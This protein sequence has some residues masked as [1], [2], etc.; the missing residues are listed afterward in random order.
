MSEVTYKWTLSQLSEVEKNGLK[1]FSTFS[2][3]GGSSLGYK[4]A[5]FDV[6]GNCEIDPQMMKL[7]KRNIKPKYTFNMDIREFNKLKDL[8]EE[9]FHLDVLDGSPPC[10]VFSMSGDREEAWNKEKAFK[11]GQAVQRL[12]DLF[13]HFLE[14]VEKLRPKVFVA[15]NVR[16]LI[17]GNAK[18]YVRE[19]IE[20]AQEKG[21]EVQLFLLNAATM[22]VPQRR[23]RVFFVGRRK[24]LS[25]DPLKL[26]FNEKPITYG[27]IRSGRG[28]KLNERSL[29][30]KR[31]VKR[32][33]DDRNMANISKRLTGKESNF[34]TVLMKNH[35]VAPT[36]AAN[37][38]FI[39]FD[40]PYYISKKDTILI[41]T[42]PMDYDFMDAPVQ[43]VCGMS[44]P[45]LMMRGIAKNIARQW[46]K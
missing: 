15:E 13:F 20:S 40:E 38:C 36:L 1:V 5:G 7:Y 37:S 43:Y 25:F 19:I 35:L 17:Q 30:Y 2:C 4:L 29:A 8:P 41:Q 32:K 10:S 34:N 27:E 46:F 31:W 44:V 14:T 12:D 23:E 45:P 21:Y 6:L 28:R 11:E 18:G 26:S 24:D 16:G 3:G 33:P 22:G 9:L 42:F 39:R